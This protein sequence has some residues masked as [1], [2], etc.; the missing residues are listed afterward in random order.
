MPVACVTIRDRDGRP[1]VHVTEAKTLF[2]AVQNGVDLFA[3]P[4]W[5]G[6]KPLRD[7]NYE[8][9]LVGDYRRWQ[10]QAASVERCRNSVR[11]P[12]SRPTTSIQVP[13]YR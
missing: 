6:P 9:W 4:Y 11:E 13:P 10:V 2:E 7:T 1:F 8:V 3:D 12:F 5:K